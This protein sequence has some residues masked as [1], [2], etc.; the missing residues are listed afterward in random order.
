MDEL[1]LKWSC[2]ARDQKVPFLGPLLLSKA[3]EFSKKLGN[4]KLQGSAGWLACFKKSQMKLTDIFIQF[5]II[6][7]H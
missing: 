7:L 3:K 6:L 1:L 5:N 2:E 4:H